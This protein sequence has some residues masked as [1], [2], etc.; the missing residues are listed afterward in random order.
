MKQVCLLELLM[1]LAAMSGCAGPSRPR[2]V[3]VAWPTVISSDDTRIRD[4][5]AD[6]LQIEARDVSAEKRPELIAWALKQV[7]D[8]PPR[9]LEEAIVLVP[10]GVA[11][12]DQ[13][14]LLMAT[15][16]LGESKWIPGPSFQE[17]LEWS[18]ATSVRPDIG[19]I[20]RFVEKTN[21]GYNEYDSG[22]TSVMEV[23]LNEKYAALS[24]VLEAGIP[25]KEKRRRYLRICIPD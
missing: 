24:G 17:A 18:R 3:V 6:V 8:L 23:C 25:D 22:L 11:E 21:F 15:R 1:T 12:P 20:Q 7:R 10:P 13:W 2:T 19:A 16:R 4:M 5:V 14:L 9:L